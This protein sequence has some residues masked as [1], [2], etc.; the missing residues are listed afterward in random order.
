M[1]KVLALFLVILVAFSAFGCND[2]GSSSGSSSDKKDKSSSSQ[3]DKNKNDEKDENKDD[4]KDEEKGKK[5]EDIT[6]TVLEATEGVSSNEQADRLFD[7]NAAT[8]WCITDF[9]GAEVIFEL[10]EPVKITGY[11]ILTGEDNETFMGRNPVSWEL[12]G[13][14]D[15]SNWVVL[16][17]KVD[18]DA[19]PEKNNVKCDFKVSG[20]D[21]EYKYYKL[22]IS[23]NKSDYCMQISEFSL[24]YNGADIE[25]SNM[26]TASS[27]VS[28]PETPAIKYSE[29]KRYAGTETVIDGSEY[30]FEVGEFIDFYNS[31]VAIGLY[32]AYS[33]SCEGEG[34]IVGLERSGDSSC[35]VTGLKVG[36]VT[37]TA[38]LMDTSYYGLGS[39]YYTSTYED[40][41]TINIVPATEKG[42]YSGGSYSGGGGYSGGYSGSTGSGCSMC[43]YTG[44]I[45]CSTCNGTGKW[46]SS[47]STPGYTAGAGGS[48][49]DSKPCQFCNKGKRDCPYC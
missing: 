11:S 20:V 15:C 34:T 28:Q 10:S 26:P 14:V 46:T 1:K 30:T 47:G 17:S 36:K 42:S 49:S 40:K 37:L 13:S 35:T 45:D 9:S 25:Y 41:I 7:F 24:D 16:D 39:D 8:K 29:G 5:Y 19:L 38:S 2:S 22:T 33:W 21:K 27:S 23:E 43:G 4:N 6:F 44:E 32:Y 12:A 31:H 48:Y 3:S 18:S